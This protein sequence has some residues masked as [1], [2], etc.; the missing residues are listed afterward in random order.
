MSL[1][2]FKRQGGEFS[3]LPFKLNTTYCSLVAAD[4]PF[5][6]QYAECHGLPLSC[7]I[8]AGNYTC[9]KGNTF[10]SSKYPS[11]LHS[12]DYMFEVRKNLVEDFHAVLSKSL[13][14]NIQ[15]KYY[16]DEDGILTGQRIIANL[17]NRVGSKSGM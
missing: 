1:E 8:P 16:T 14:F 7:P 3:I 11:F 15:T 9:K 5:Y 4:N 17:Q 2:I 13:K 10:E 12:G 6:A